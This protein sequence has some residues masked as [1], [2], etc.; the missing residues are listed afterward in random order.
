[1][2]SIYGFL[3]LH[4]VLGFGHQ[5]AWQGPEGRRREAGVFVP[6]ASFLP[7]PFPQNHGSVRWSLLC[8][9]L[10]WALGPSPSSSLTT[11]QGVPLLLLLVRLLHHPCWFP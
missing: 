2:G 4:L 9:Y 10:L 5:E 6:P 7:S 11:L 3:T 8:C 1:M